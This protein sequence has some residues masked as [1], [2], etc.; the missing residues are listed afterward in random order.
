MFALP[1]PCF[2]EGRTF[3]LS[4]GEAERE[5]AEGSELKGIC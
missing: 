4:N 3:F 2:P 1:L 5:A